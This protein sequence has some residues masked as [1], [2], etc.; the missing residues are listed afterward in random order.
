VGGRELCRWRRVGAPQQIDVLRHRVQDT[1][2][3]M[4]FSNKPGVKSPN[5]HG[6]TLRVDEVSLFACERHM[7][8]S[9]M[10]TKTADLRATG[11]HANG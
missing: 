4:R 10:P 6:V 2:V 7:Q 8:P 1:Q 9:R 5:G 3:T 11:A